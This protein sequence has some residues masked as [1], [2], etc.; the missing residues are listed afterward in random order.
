MF[1]GYQVIFDKC[2]KAIFSN[3]NAKFFVKY[4]GLNCFQVA[5]SYAITCAKNRAIDLKDVMIL[6]F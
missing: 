5:R 4:E 3:L 6:E 2:G 1:Q